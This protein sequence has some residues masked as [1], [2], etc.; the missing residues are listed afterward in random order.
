MEARPYRFNRT[1]PA[2]AFLWL[3]VTTPLGLHFRPTDSDFPQ[4]YMGGLLVRL[5]ETAELYPIPN[6]ESLDNPGMNPASKARPRYWDLEGQSKVPD[7][8][9]WMLPPTS[10]LPFVPLSYLSFRAA[11]WVWVAILTACVWATALF[12]GRFHR[13]L[14]GRESPWEG[15]LALLIVLSP[16]AAR[17]IRIRNITPP[18][19][20][21]FAV[22]TLCLIGRERPRRAIGAGVSIV[23]GA[24]FKYATFVLLP[25]VVLTRWWRTVAATALALGGV[26]ALGVCCMD[27][28]LW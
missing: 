7:I 19:A 21:C 23:L 2:L 9:H 26:I 10:A 15:L 16:M 1:C 24:L 6:P 5:G 13:I 8:T 11:E 17:A 20:V 14:L 25:L 27:G 4:F 22:A 3:A 12:A 28:P 18:I